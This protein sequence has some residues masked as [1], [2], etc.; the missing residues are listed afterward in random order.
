VCVCSGGD[1]KEK[2]VM[3]DV[4]VAGNFFALDQ[5]CPDWEMGAKVGAFRLLG[6]EHVMKVS[7]DA[8]IR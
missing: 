4:E 6:V 2:V 5:S 1:G 8:D 7:P 3:S